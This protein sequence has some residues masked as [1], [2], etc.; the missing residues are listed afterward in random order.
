V[1]VP[2]RPGLLSATGLLH[3]E[4]R[5]DFSLTRLVRAEAS[6][7]KSLTEGF[8]T[9]AKRG[10]EWLDGEGERHGA[11]LWDADLRY[12]GQNFELIME[13]SS[14]SIDISALARLCEAFHQRH[15]D[16]YGYDMPEQPVEIVN[17]RLVV[18]GQREPVPFETAAF[19]R[20]GFEDAVLDHRK[21]WFP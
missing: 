2:P 8:A 10:A 13:L 17:L 3:A 4:L 1:L 16:Y 7:L 15:K 18:T 20:G 9:L 14:D 11:Y 12:L 19:A 5:G 6:G 21:V